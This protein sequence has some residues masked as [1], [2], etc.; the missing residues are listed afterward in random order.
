MRLIFE[1]YWRVPLDRAGDLS[2]TVVVIESDTPTPRA[3][4]RSDEDER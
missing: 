3:R 2:S 4:T 1:R